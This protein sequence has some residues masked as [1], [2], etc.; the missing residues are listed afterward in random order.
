MEPVSFFPWRLVMRRSMLALC[1][2]LAVSTLGCDQ[3]NKI[4]ADV[5]A[6]INKRRGRTPA[7]PAPAP[8]RDPPKHPVAAPPPPGGA[9][10]SPGAKGPPPRPPPH[11]A[12][13]R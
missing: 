12:P 1:A 11:R 13:G 10:P 4:K 8:P 6:A 7:T 2:L 5:Q 9:R 3:I